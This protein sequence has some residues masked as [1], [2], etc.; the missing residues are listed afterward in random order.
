MRILLYIFIAAITYVPQAYAEI[1]I[2]VLI[3]GVNQSRLTIQS[4]ELLNIMTKEYPTEKTEDEIATWLKVEKKR[5]LKEFTPDPLY[6]DVDIQKYEKEFLIPTLNAE[7]YWMRKRIE[8]GRTNT[9]FKVLQTETAGI[10]TLY[11]YKLTH[12]SEPVYTVEDGELPFY[13]GE[14]T[15]LVYDA[16]TK[17]KQYLGDIV[18]INY[19]PPHISDSGAS[20][21]YW[22]FSLFGRSPAKVPENA[23][24]L[25]K[26]IVDGVE[27]YTVD[28]TSQNKRP[29]QIWVDPTKDFCVRRIDYMSRNKNG[30]T[31]ARR[32]YKKF[33]KFGEVWF[34]QVTEGVVFDKAGSIS[35]RHTI[36]T[37]DAEFN[38]DFPKDFFKVNKAF[39]RSEQDIPATGFL[40]DMENLMTEPEHPETYNLLLCGPQSLLRICELLNVPTHLDEIKKMSGFSPNHGTTMLGIKQAAI[41]KGLA[42]TGVRASIELIRRGKVPMPTIAYVNSNHFLVLES[43]NKTGVNITDPAEKYEPRLTYDKLAEIWDGELL[44]FDIKK[45]RSAQKQ[46]PLAFIKTPEFDFGKAIGG[47][48]IK[49]TFPIKNIGQKNLKIISV[50]E[51]C[52]CTASVPTHTEITTGKTGDVSVV[53]TVPSSNQFIE[54]KIFVLTNDPTQNTLTLTV[55]GEA[56]TPLRTFPKSVNVGTQEPLKNPLT[57]RISLHTQED[58]HLRNVSTDSEHITATLNTKTSIPHIEVKLLKT[59]PIGLV[60]HNVK[61]DYV[62]KGKQATHT[63]PIFGHVLGDLQVVPKRLFLGLIKD[64]TSVSKKVTISSRKKKLFQISNIKTNTKDVTVTFKKNKSQTEHQ[65]TMTIAKIKSGNLSGEIVIQT[66]NT[67]ESTIRV[68]FFGVIATLNEK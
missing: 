18:F 30:H 17:V 37:I 59:L 49:H 5:A 23:K 27:C 46:V 8:T 20:W 10:P 52:A 21:E 25:G 36:K 39:F 4:G 2:D 9:L 34:P 31:D 45:G 63:I 32:T 22:H 47:S 26:E 50:T 64:P 48:Q 15:F 53:L 66:N 19:E 13:P 35:Y 57:K 62:Y 60:A 56:F 58:T 68:P 16:Q 24:F 67:A 11:Q 28:F 54:E 42:P 29:F 41:Y 40:P 6:P 51:T 7:T 12:V 3:E 44:I 33:K 43:V 61:V 38:V 65:I 55:K 1:T 14:L